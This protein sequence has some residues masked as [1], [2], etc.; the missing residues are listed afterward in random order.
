MLCVFDPELSTGLFHEFRDR[1][2]IDVAEPGEEVVLDLEIQAADEP[3]DNSAPPGEVHGG[4]RLMDGPRVLDAPSI[5]PGQRKLRL[6]HAMCDLKH[7]TQGHTRHQPGYPVVE[8]DDPDGVEQQRD[9][10]G[11]GE[12]DRFAGD[13]DHQL[14]ALRARERLVADA[15]ADELSEIIK[16]LPL[17]GQQSVKRPEVEVLPP[18]I[19]ETPLM[20]SQPGEETEIDVGVMARD[21]DIRVMQ[22][23]VLP[24]PQVGAPADQLQ[25][26]RHEFVDPGVV[27]IGL[28]ATVVLDIEANPGRREAEQH[29]QQEALPPSLVHEDQQRIRHRETGEED[30]R[31]HVHLPAV[32]WPAAGGSEILFDPAPQLELEGVAVRKFQTDS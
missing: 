16:K 15:T 3:C 9:P 25:R 10:E 11:H 19:R 26:H 1:G 13:E 8:Q 32:A 27:G 20:R 7:H 29:G 6:F 5:L 31:L 21:I 18:V 23:D 28:M 12:K 2:I 24:P 14:P 17:D 22:D 4:L 30:G